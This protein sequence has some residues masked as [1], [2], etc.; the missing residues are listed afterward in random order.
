MSQL[1]QAASRESDSSFQLFPTF[2]A[3]SARAGASTLSS[4]TSAPCW[5]LLSSAADMKA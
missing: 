2:F 3:A 4:V 1:G 5:R